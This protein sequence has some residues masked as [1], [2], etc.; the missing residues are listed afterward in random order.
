[1]MLES[2][3]ISGLIEGEGCFSISF[4]LRQ[5]LKL[6]IEVRPS[7]SV[8]LNQRDLDLIKGLHN[9]FNCGGVRYSRSDRTYKYEV[10]SVNDLMNIVIPFFEQYP[11]KGSKFQDFLIFS[12][13]CKS[14][15]G[16][17]HMS[18]KCLPEIIDRAYQMNPSGKRKYA[19]SDLLK[20]LD[21]SKV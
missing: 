6:G 11:L 13:I 18:K 1:M 21:E 12:E 15:K 16:N 4:T 20:I 5:K 14:I 3:Y 17:L 7:F 10:R 8:S 19:K 9:Y 2:W